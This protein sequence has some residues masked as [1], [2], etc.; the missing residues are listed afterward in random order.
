MGINKLLSFLLL[1][2]LLWALPSASEALPEPVA[3]AYSVSTTMTPT[4]PTPTPTPYFKLRVWNHWR[5]QPH[6][7]GNIELN[8]GGVFYNLTQNPEG[9]DVVITYLR[10]F[11]MWPASTDLGCM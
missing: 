3:Q 11:A 7:E 10:S 4:E 2:I 1:Q 5:A 8:F 6:F 9:F